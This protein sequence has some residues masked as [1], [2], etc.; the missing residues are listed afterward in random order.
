MSTYEVIA[1]I[2]VVRFK[3]ETD[4]FFSYMA[5]SPR[6]YGPVYTYDLIVE[7]EIFVGELQATTPAP[8]VVKI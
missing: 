8:F 4:D 5:W 3:K 2:V 1:P 7:I 6:R